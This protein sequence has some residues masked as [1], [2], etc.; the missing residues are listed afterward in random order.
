MQ[1]LK[2]A[3]VRYDHCKNCYSH[4]WYIAV[5]TAG[6]EVCGSHVQDAEI[7]SAAHTG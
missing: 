4:I 7:F 2:C 6:V 5:G 1:W 3:K